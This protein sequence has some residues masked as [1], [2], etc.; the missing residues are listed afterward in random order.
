MAEVAR[1]RVVVESP[2]QRESS[3]EPPDRL[4][5]DA[6]G[7]DEQSLPTEPSEATLYLC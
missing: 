5:A 6:A 4:T 3:D 7:T 2:L 1:D